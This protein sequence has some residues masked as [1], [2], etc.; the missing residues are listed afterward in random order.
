MRFGCV[1]R[2]VPSDTLRTLTTRFSATKDFPAAH[3]MDTTWFAVD[4]EG[5]V[6]RFESGEA[7]AVP[8]A[9]ATGGGAAEP[10]FDVLVLDVACVIDRLAAA[11][12]EERT[13][14]GFPRRAVLVVDPVAPE[15]ASDYRTAAAVAPTLEGLDAIVV[16]AAGPR[17]L[18]TKKALAPKALARLAKHP[19][20]KLLVP[21]DEIG[22]WLEDDAANVF[23]FDHDDRNDG[24]PGAYRRVAAPERAMRI[25]EVPEIVREEVESL[26][27]PVKFSDAETLHLA[28]HMKNEEAA[29]WGDEP[30]RGIDPA[31]AARRAEAEITARKSAAEQ[32]KKRALVTL[33]VLAAIVIAMLLLRRR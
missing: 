16:R 2:Q 7:G 13:F 11:P 9:A 30:L 12:P 14:D 29:T 32:K 27:L 15:G 5:R 10:S 25:D 31:T 17:V 33:V 21:A 3:S 19:D 1:A 22:E 26:R 4:E 20:V 23:R 8:L 6:A 24:E 18:V 28:D